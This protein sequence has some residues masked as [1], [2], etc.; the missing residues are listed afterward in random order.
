MW[1]CNSNFNLILT[2]PLVEKNSLFPDRSSLVAEFIHTF[3]FFLKNRL[4]LP[5]A[6]LQINSLVCFMFFFW[7][8]GMAV[9]G[10]KLKYYPTLDAWF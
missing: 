7:G 4:M 6:N 2:H 3:V 5:K 8:E 1:P 10:Q 9:S